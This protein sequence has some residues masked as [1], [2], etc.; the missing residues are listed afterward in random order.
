[1]QSF[2][3]VLQSFV[4]V[5]M[6]QVKKHFLSLLM[7]SLLCFTTGVFALEEIDCIN[8]DG[9][10]DG[11]CKYYRI[12]DTRG[13]ELW[14]VPSE[15]R[16]E[17][18]DK[19]LAIKGATFYVYAPQ[20]G[21]YDRDGGLF[22]LEL[23]S[24]GEPLKNL[25]V[26]KSDEERGVVKIRIGSH[27]Q[28]ENFMLGTSNDA[29]ATDPVVSLVYNFYEPQL[30][31]Y[32]EGK[33]V[34]SKTL[35]SYEVGDTMYVDVEAI[36]P[37][38]PN[39]GKLDSTLDRPFYFLPE[40]DSK[41]LQFLSEGGANL[42]RPDDNSILLD[43]KGGKA[44]FMVVATKAVQDGSTFSMNAF[45]DGKDK[46]GNQ[47]Y[48]LTE[49]FPG[50]YQFSNPDMPTFDKAAIYDTDGDGIGDSIAT[51]FG[52]NLDSAEIEKF[53]YSWP[54]DDSFKDYSGDVKQK[55][56]VYGLPDVN[57]ELQKDPATGAVKAK[58]CTSVGNRCETLQT[59]L[60]DSIGAAIQS[61]T[62]LKGKGDTD[63]LIVTFN[64]PMD[65]S[66]TTGRG[67]LL[68]GEKL[69]ATAFSKDGTQWAF[70]VE[71]DRV[72]V[73]DML[74]I[75][76]NCSAKE[77]PDGILTAADGVPTSPKNQAVPVKDAGRVYVDNDKNG[78]YDRDGDGRM[79]SVSVGFD[80]PITEKDLKNMDITFYWL[81]NDGDVISIKPNLGDLEI[82]ADGHVLGYAIDKP[83]TYDI[84]NMLT[85]IDS[86]YAKDNKEY[87]Y[88]K[89]VNKVTVDGKATKDTTSYGMHDYMAPVIAA[90]FLNPESFQMVEPDKFRLTFSE[91]MDKDESSVTEDALEFYVDG[92]STPLKLKLSSAEWSEDGKSVVMYLEAGE[93]LSERMNPGDS[94]RLNLDKSFFVDREGNSV[95]MHKMHDELPKVMVEG[96]PRVIMKTM[97]MADLNKAQELSERA[98]PFT[99]KNVKDAKEASD[100][101]SLGVLMDIGFS[102]IMKKNSKGEQVPDMKDIGLHWEL[103]VYTNLGAYVGHA[104]GSIACDD[105]F[106]KS[107]GSKEGNC[108]DNPDKLYVRWNMRSDD[109][110]RVGVGLY[111]AK[112]KV[113]VYGAK[114]DFKIERIFRWGIS[115][116]NAKKR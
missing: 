84:M 46:E 91:A 79:D 54:D 80:T 9:K 98:K 106:F 40:G 103:Y 27:Y 55:K 36:I 52:G 83:E 112:F 85:S 104:S 105:D 102:T 115:A 3:C 50:N 4:E 53:A 19:S 47:Q 72:H 82:S 68:N 34:T 51:W 29:S 21:N 30:K 70:A 2:F 96:D 25:S 48:V 20:E 75:E 42:K 28:L 7:L 22:T 14:V 6:L 11:R 97:S 87:G 71:K 99:I 31:Y 24:N 58:V 56:N 35:L 114:E 32:V 10:H 38:G 60:T 92:S 13:A 57:V 39:S 16:E 33:E 15:K 66:W 49:P 67:L 23:M 45:E 5:V 63:T 111:L 44:K 110:R 17:S 100:Q 116:K 41:S 93:D 81:N 86:S 74:K 69:K 12:F 43:V 64:K 59:V 109:G 18:Y 107:E 90:T 61:A 76:T 62:L 94:V 113:K 65:S 101:S 73:D 108:L 89:I 8:Y 95:T 26:V 1:M 37:F 88:T 77:C 78:F